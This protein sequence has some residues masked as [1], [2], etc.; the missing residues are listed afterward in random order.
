M[1]KLK[2]IKLSHLQLDFLLNK[3]EKKGFSFLLNHGVYCTRCNAICA[4]GV[5]NYT[6]R[7]NRF[8]D[9]VVDGECAVCDQKVTRV[10]EFGENILFF[11]KA[12]DYRES[13]QN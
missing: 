9:I 4:K 10:M 11:E 1:K 5:V 13:L 2:E 7:L 12:M 3:E 8:N 6:L